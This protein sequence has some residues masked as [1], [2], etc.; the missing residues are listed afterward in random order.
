MISSPFD[1]LHQSHDIDSKIIAA[2]ERVS[3]VFRV[4]L[5]NE[6]KTHS[7]SPIQVQTLIFLLYHTEEKRK[8]SYLAQ[9]FNLAKATISDTIK[10]LEQKGL[11]R[12][13]RELTDTRSFVLHLTDKGRDVA[14]QTALFTKEI[15]IPVAVLADH[16]KENLYVSLIGII[17]HLYS[18]GLITIQRMCSTCIH[19]R[20]EK[21]GTL[22]FCRLL[23]KELHPTEFQVDCPDHQYLA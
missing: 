21:E 6:S 23:N 10:V 15:Q 8:V 18:A 5:W 12:K 7:L 3:Q 17:R 9:E 19:Y 22:H 2:L 13:E 1:L 11:I 20:S 14:V 16:D 4:L